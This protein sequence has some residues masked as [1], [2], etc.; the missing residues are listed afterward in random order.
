MPTDNDLRALAEAAFPLPWKLRMSRYGEDER[1]L[2]LGCTTKNWIVAYID[3][4][5]EDEWE[6]TKANWA[7]IEAA[8]NSILA[9][10]DRIAALEAAL[11]E[12]RIAAALPE[13]TVPLPGTG[14]PP[15]VQDQGR[16]RS[17]S[18]CRPPRPGPWV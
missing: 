13:Y 3:P 11:S 15:A 4:K 7:F 17:R 16:I 14:D 1:S 12:E 10:L 8:C 6:G 18:P 9:L 5:Y 2:V